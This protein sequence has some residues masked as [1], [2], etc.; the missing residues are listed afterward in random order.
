MLLSDARV[1][2]D[3]RANQKTNKEIFDKLGDIQ[4]RSREICM[5]IQA[6]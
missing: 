6:F 4:P 5:Y 1:E 3:C 2:F